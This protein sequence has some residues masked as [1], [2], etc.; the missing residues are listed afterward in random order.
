MTVGIEARGRN[1]R[2]GF[3]LAGV[4]TVLCLGSVAYINWYH[5]DAPR[6]SG[7]ESR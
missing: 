6:P 5:T 7:L 1:R 3:F 2:L 4:F